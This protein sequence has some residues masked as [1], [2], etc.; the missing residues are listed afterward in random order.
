MKTFDKECYVM[1]PEQYNG[2]IKIYKGYPEILFEEHKKDYTYYRFKFKNCEFDICIMDNNP[3]EVQQRIAYIETSNV[4]GENKII[5]SL[6]KDN[7]LAYY[8]NQLHSI[9]HI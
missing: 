6:S 7:I 5:F 2:N 3:N 8:E 9:K 1:F 4:V